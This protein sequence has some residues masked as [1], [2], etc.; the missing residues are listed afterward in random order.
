MLRPFKSPVSVTASWL[1]SAAAIMS[2]TAAH[3]QDIQLPPPPSGI[4]SGLSKDLIAPP[5]AAPKPAE[6]PAAPA[7]AAPAPAVTAQPAPAAFTLRAEIAD[8]IARERGMSRED[9]DALTKFYDGRQGAP[10]WV[11]AN[12]LNKNAKALIAEFENAADYALTPSAFK[13]APLSATSPAALADAEVDLT[14]NAVRYARHAR[15][16]RADPAALSKA[17]DRKAQ[18]LADAGCAEDT[19]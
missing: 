16:G 10:L 18:M 1:V 6:T 19:R 15:G 11:D 17:I 14:T 2:A 5:E 7:V 9:R 12:G 13:V 8:N 3:A 4:F